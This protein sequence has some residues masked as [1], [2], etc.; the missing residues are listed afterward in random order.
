MKRVVFT[1]MVLVGL[2]ALMACGSSKPATSQLAVSPS[3]VSVETGKTVQF[4]ATQTGTPFPAVF[5]YVNDIQNGDY[6]VGTI[7][8]SGLYI[9][10]GTVPNPAKVKVTAKLTTDLTQVATAEVTLT[11]GTPVTIT[12]TP[13]ETAARMSEV[14]ARS[15]RK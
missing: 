13:T 12:L 9:A 5:W 4:T 3:G 1:S 10:P 7:D 11:P 6:T 8:Y 2:A 15:S 14:C